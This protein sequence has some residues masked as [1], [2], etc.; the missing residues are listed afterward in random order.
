MQ[1]C[2]M[3]VPPQLHLRVYLHIH[4]DDDRAVWRRTPD[5]GDPGRGRGLDPDTA[6]M[7]RLHLSKTYQTHTVRNI[8][9]LAYRSSSAP[10]SFLPVC[11]Q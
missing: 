9:L 10:W 7:L 11:M 1:P 3:C 5:G 8:F 4:I 6:A 2:K